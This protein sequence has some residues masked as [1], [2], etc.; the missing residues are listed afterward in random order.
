MKNV[1]L[2]NWFV[3]HH[4]QFKK[5]FTNKMCNDNKNYHNNKK[6]NDNNVKLNIILHKIYIYMCV[7]IYYV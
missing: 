6:F 1:L 5:Y 7:Y 4:F 2:I 3:L